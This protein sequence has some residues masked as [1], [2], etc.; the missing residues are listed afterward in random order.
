MGELSFYLVTRIV[1]F[2]GFVAGVE[3]C[4]TC[5]RYAWAENGGGRLL[6]K[7]EKF[8]LFLLSHFKI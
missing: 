2:A 8:Y 5:K 7:L 1:A 3:Y 4:A 6:C